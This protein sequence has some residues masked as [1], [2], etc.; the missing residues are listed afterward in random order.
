MTD[1]IG[2]SVVDES[3]EKL[4]ALNLEEEEGINA[5]DGI[6]FVNYE[7]ESRLDSVMRLVGRDLSEPYSG[8]LYFL[9]LSAF[10]LFEPYVITGNILLI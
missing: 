9:H 4:E 3:I 6:K 7:D 8:K 1:N 2:N 10:F 5:I